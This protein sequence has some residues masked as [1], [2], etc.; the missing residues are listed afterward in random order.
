MRLL[1]ALTLSIISHIGLAA[2]TVP[3]TGSVALDWMLSNANMEP[4]GLYQDIDEGYDVVMIFW[5]TWC[6]VCHDLLPEIA[7]LQ[8]QFKN[9]AQNGGKKVK[10]YALSIWE[11]ND[12]VEYLD[13]QELAI[14]IL[15]KAD[16]VA[17]RYGVKL[18]PGVI[19]VGGDKKVL[20]KSEPKSSVA[21]VITHIRHALSL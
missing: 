16:S 14:P 1:F 5:S 13:Q 6:N 21:T 7:K 12:P 9:D 8:Q 4:V 19:V 10:F 2:P 18:T 20:Y 15:M 11:N 17:N 3:E